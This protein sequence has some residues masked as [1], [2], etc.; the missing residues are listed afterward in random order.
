MG[1]RE[2]RPIGE[3]QTRMGGQRAQ[4]GGFDRVV[5]CEVLHEQRAAEQAASRQLRGEL[6]GVCAAVGAAAEHLGE[7]DGGDRGA[8]GDRLV[9][10][11]V[12]R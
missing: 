7:V 3:R 8:A 12:G 10:R 4:A 11:L 6:G 1:E 2:A 9:A 5:G